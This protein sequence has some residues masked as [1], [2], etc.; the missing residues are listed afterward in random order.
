M[1]K[2]KSFD[3]RGNEDADQLLYLTETVGIL[4]EDFTQRIRRIVLVIITNLENNE[5]W[6]EE[7]ILKLKE[8][9]NWLSIFSETF[10]GML[11]GQLLLAFQ[12]QSTINKNK[13]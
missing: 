7:E 12:R 10:K 11:I 2:N 8:E 13:K 1:N 5:E 6:V 3:C 4:S 9:M